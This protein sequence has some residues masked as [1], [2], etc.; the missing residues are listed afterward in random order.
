[1]ALEGSRAAAND[2]L[3][4]IRV[5]PSPWHATARAA[6]MLRG[7][8]FEQLRE[9]DDWELKSGAAHYVV[10]DGSS[11]I[12]FRL[13]DSPDVQPVRVIVAHTDSPGFRIKP[14]GA[15]DRDHLLALGVE[16]YGGPIVATFADRDLSLAGRVLVRRASGSSELESQLVN[17]DRPLLRLPTP[18]IHLN[19]DVNEA[20]L[21]FDPQ[22]ELALVLAGL[23]EQVPANRQFA[24]M[25][26]KELGADVERIAAWE[27]AV[28]D[29]QPGGFF[30]MNEE[31]IASA[32]LDNLASCHASLSALVSA[33]AGGNTMVCALFDHEEVGSQSFKGAEGSFLQD[34]LERILEGFGTGRARQRQ[35]ISR[36]LLLSADMA[37]GFHPSFA[38][39]YDELHAVR[40]N[41]GP[42]I[43]INAKQR[44][45][46]DGAGEAYFAALCELEGVACQRY[47]HRNNL[48]C[49]STVGPI[50]AARLGIRTIDVGNPMWSMHSAREAAGAHDHEP[51]I[52]VMRRFYSDES[53]LAHC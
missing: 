21:K 3:E 9:E 6:E 18:A 16:V 36:S 49:G 39:Y 2:L 27:L 7:A 45:A 47:V 32:R 12:A 30:G 34:V 23:A 28:A 51:M 24:Q 17:F 25:L 38:R 53:T 22:E 20:G 29:S 42:A 15:Q 33:L 1:M 40:L 26:A 35:V 52:Q 37:H 13:G 4:Y 50:T 19:R 8:G 14:R 48:P 31:F 5:S 41:G 46:T 44:Y 10:R 43:K 11:I